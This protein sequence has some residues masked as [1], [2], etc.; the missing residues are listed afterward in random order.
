LWLIHDFNPVGR[1]GKRPGAEQRA[2]HLVHSAPET[3]PAPILRP[4]YQIRTQGVPFNVSHH[5][6]E[7]FVAFHRKRLQADLAQMS[8]P[9]L[10]LDSLP[11]LRMRIR[12]KPGNQTPN[13]SGRRV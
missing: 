13:L 5:R 12:Q 3:S 4:F 9:H 6:L 8:V 10:M 1:Y 11:T 7:M 2:A